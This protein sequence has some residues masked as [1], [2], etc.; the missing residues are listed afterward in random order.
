MD[1]VKLYFEAITNILGYELK[2]ELKEDLLHSHFLSMFYGTKASW[3]SLDSVLTRLNASFR[4]VYDLRKAPGLFNSKMLSAWFNNKDTPIIG[5]LCAKMYDPRVPQYIDFS[6]LD[7]YHEHHRRNMLNYVEKNG[8]TNQVDYET[9]VEYAKTCGV[10]VDLQLY[11]EENGFESLIWTHS[12]QLEE[13][14]PYDVDE[15]VHSEVDVIS[16]KAEL[17]PPEHYKFLFSLF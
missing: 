11:L 6:E 3:M 16:F 7:S 17:L 4:A 13:I 8:I 1:T 5:P 12:E 9:R 15:M 10:D 14:S 2:L